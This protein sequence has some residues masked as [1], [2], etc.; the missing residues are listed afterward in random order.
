MVALSI[1][2][3]L[4]VMILG[5]HQRSSKV[6]ITV[7]PPGTTRDVESQLIWRDLS[8]VLNL[9]ELIR[10]YYIPNYLKSLH[11]EDSNR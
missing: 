9:K 7:K 2:V 10:W 11:S 1:F 4:S 6:Y 5:R 8:E 3:I